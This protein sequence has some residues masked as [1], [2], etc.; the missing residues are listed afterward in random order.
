ME[1]AQILEIYDSLIRAFP[2]IERKGKKTPYTSANTYMSSFIGND[3]R[4][5]F[6][7]SQADIATLIQDHKAQLMEQHGK[8]LKDFVAI[9]DKLLNDTA[10]LQ[11]YFQKSLDHTNSLKPKK[12]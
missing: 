2:S 7:L 5:A 6:R 3:G 4:M 9:P 10:L 11:A 8:V 12:K 1:S